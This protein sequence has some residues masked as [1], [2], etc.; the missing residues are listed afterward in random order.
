MIETFSVTANQ[1]LTM[2]VFML[3]GF[4]MKKKSI[5]G[6]GVGSALSAVVVNISL[7]ALSFYTFS[8]NFNISAIT[9][10]K[11]FLIA[12]IITMIVSFFISKGLARM[13]SKDRLQQDIYRYSFIIPNI[14][15]MG[16][17]IVSAV[18]GE[19]ALLSM[20]IY[21]IPFNIMIFS[22]GIYILN[23]NR[24]W[25]I[26]KMLNPNIIAI[27]IGIVFGLAGIKLPT[28]VENIVVSAK[29]CMS[30]LAMVLTGFV[31]AS[32]PLKPVFLDMKSYIAAFL[33]A[34]I[35]PMAALLI[36]L[37][38]DIRGMLMIIIVATL[39]MPFGLNSV[40]FPEA[41][42]GDSTTGAKTCFI[43]NIMS[44]ITIPVVFSI[45]SIFL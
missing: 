42:G 45:V 1:V 12:G 36:L 8:Q 38:F 44:I 13:F 10:Y 39:S 25:S 23:P 29:V 27:F 28:L 9:S 5:G 19:E 35:I 16:Y 20:M 30:P 40:V 26:K 11:P 33:R 31:L 7:P 15:Y 37:L 14:G 32:V 2:F 17:P 6:D 34:V 18:F 43:S 41:F 24:E 3:L 21:T 22:Y 4:F